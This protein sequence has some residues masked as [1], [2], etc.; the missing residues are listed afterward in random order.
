M[1]KYDL[2]VLDLCSNFRPIKNACQVRSFEPREPNDDR[3][4]NGLI[5]VRHAERIQTEAPGPT[6]ELRLI[7]IKNANSAPTLVKRRPLNAVGVESLNDISD[8][9][10][11]FGLDDGS[12]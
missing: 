7:A 11:E 1:V 6:A 3:M 2:K 9:S 4:Q 8:E 12:R 5:T 10:S